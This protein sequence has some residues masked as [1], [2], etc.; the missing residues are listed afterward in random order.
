MRRGVPPAVFLGSFTT[1]G[2]SHLMPDP[3]DFCLFLFSLGPGPCLSQLKP[4]HPPD[5][6][7]SGLGREVM[8]PVHTRARARVSGEKG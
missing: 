7:A 6:V 2:K 4:A 1:K 5:D 3:E 8:I